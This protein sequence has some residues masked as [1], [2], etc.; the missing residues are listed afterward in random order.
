MSNISQWPIRFIQFYTD[1]CTGATKIR[2]AQ[3]ISGHNLTLRELS[4]IISY[5]AVPTCRFQ[6]HTLLYY[7]YSNAFR[8][9]RTSRF[10]ASSLHYL[11][12]QLHRVR[13]SSVTLGFV[14]VMSKVKV[15]TQN[16]EIQIQKYSNFYMF[17]V[18]KEPDT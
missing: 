1:F 5:L 11:F 12:P 9:K 8:F 4:T 17:Q 13:L 6:P 16:S 7:C 18:T 10:A 14:H 15:K 3:K 2:Y